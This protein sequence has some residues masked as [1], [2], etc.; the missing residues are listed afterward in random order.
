MTQAPNGPDRIRVATLSQTRPL[1]FDL[2]PDAAALQEIAG[3]LGLLDLRKLRLRG[4]L[5]AQGPRD[6]LLR[7]EL[8]ATVTQPCVITLEPVT[9]RIDQP[10]TRRFSPD[11]D[12]VEAEAGGEVEMPDDVTFEPLESEIDLHRVMI[13]ALSLALPDWPRRDGAEL[14]SIRVAEDGV[15]P[16]TD[17]EVK[18][19]AGLAALRDKLG[20]DD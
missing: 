16:L 3:T 7:A 20:K 9:T 5:Q 11:P 10:V 1:A 14:G 17:D 13:E 19:F 12:P 2:V 18:P 4:D 15:A 6:W 8:G